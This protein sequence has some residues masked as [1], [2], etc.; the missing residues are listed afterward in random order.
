[1]DLESIRTTLEQAS[2]AS[3]AI[4]LL[5]GLF[6]SFNPVA[7]AAIPVSLAYVTKARE[8]KQAAL[9][10][11][12]FISGLI[13][14]HV[15]LGLTASLGGQWFQ[16][17]LGR[18]WGLALGPLLIALGLVWLGWVR[19]P[20]PAIAFRARRAAT[21]WGAFALGVPFSVAICPFCSPVLLILLGVAAGVGSPLFGSLLLL[22]FAVG[23]VVPIIIGSVAIGWLQN[24]SGLARFQRVFE[25]I[26]GTLLI[27]AGLY[28]LNAVWLA[29]PS[30]AI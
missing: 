3:L 19:I 30:L 1:M 26:G 22:A 5:A 27:L 16:A 14:T 2:L 25:L 23:R 10:G 21:A 11:G 24:L 28:M 8:P 17:L 6:F 13:L 15:L 29:V 18:Q 7:F 4:S 20:L 12:M 9:F